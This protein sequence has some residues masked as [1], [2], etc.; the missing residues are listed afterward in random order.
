MKAIALSMV[1]SVGF[2][3]V[4]VVAMRRQRL[5]EQAALLWFLVSLVMVVRERHA[6]RSISSTTWP[7]SSGSPTRPTSC[8]CWPCC[9][10]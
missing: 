6:A 5:R 8:S 2:L 9:S 10:S 4:S 1:V 3:V 7:V